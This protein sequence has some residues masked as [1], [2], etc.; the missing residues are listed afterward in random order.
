MLCLLIL[1]ALVA[2]GFVPYTSSKSYTWASE[3]IVD[4]SYPGPTTPDH[5]PIVNA[6]ATGDCSGLLRHDSQF[7]ARPVV[8]YRDGHLGSSLPLVPTNPCVI[9]KAPMRND[10]LLAIGAMALVSAAVV[11][12]LSRRR[13]RAAFEAPSPALDSARPDSAT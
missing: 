6:V 5:M 13:R 3:A 12:E 2:A 7:G 8:R 4:P 1:I 9:G 10:L 11:V